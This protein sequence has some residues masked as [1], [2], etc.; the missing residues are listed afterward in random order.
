MQLANRLDLNTLPGPALPQPIPGYA[1]AAPPR[2]PNRSNDPATTN[3]VPLRADIAR[4][5]MANIRDL[6]HLSGAMGG[7]GA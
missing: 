3:D 1:H 4:W 7:A 2:V 6:G 5:I